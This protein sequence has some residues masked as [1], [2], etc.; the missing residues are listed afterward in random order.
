[1]AEEQGEAVVEQ[2]AV[3]SEGEVASITEETTEPEVPALPSDEEEF[4]VPEKFKGKSLEDVIKS[5]Q[6]LEK[7]KGQKEEPQEA[8]E[9]TKEVE[10]KA[11]EEP[12]P[13]DPT[14]YK[15]Y[16]T[17][18][19]EKGELSEEQYQ[20]LAEQGYDRE[21]VDAEIDYYNYKQERAVKQIVEPLGGGTEKFKE[22]A[23]WA[24]QNKTEAEINEFNAALAAAP[25]LAQQAMLKTLYAEYDSG[26]S[27][28][29]GGP[30]HTNTP[31]RATSKGYANES[32]FFKD[33]STAEYKTDKNYAAQVEAKLAQSDTSKW[34]F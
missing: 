25:K 34:S 30:I 3:L 20:E 23:K 27:K 4:V 21:A 13:I 7:F 32:E 26:T 17:T 5:Y 19:M 10:P 22:V 16:T 11:S 29:G 1:M 9:P 24:K 12:A 2:S 14:K 33:I 8:P 18:Y 28:E 31:Q 15:E 6:E